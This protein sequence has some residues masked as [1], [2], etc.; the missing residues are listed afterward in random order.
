[1]K[2]TKLL[3]AAFMLLVSQNV[4][5]QM[6][7]LSTNNVKDEKIARLH[8]RIDGNDARFR[9][10]ITGPVN[11]VYNIK[12]YTK[13]NI[14]NPESYHGLLIFHFDI[15][16]FGDRLAYASVTIEGIPTQPTFKTDIS[17]SKN[18]ITIKLTDNNILLDSDFD[19]KTGTAVRPKDPFTTVWGCT[20]GQKTYDLGI[21]LKNNQNLMS[22]V[23]YTCSHSSA[24]MARNGASSRT[25]AITGKKTWGGRIDYYPPVNFN[26]TQTITYSITQ[27]AQNLGIT[28]REAAALIVYEGIQSI[29]LNKQHSAWELSDVEEDIIRYCLYKLYDLDDQTLM[30]VETKIKEN[31]ARSMASS[32]SNLDKL[33][34]IKLSPETNADEL[35]ILAQKTVDQYRKNMSAAV[36]EVQY[37]DAGVGCALAQSFLITSYALKKQYNEVDRLFK[38]GT[39]LLSKKM[40]PLMKF[41]MATCYYLSLTKEYDK[42]AIYG[43]RAFQLLSEVPNIQD[44][45]TRRDAAEKRQELMYTFQNVILGGLIA[46][47]EGKLEARKLALTTYC[48]FCQ[49]PVIETNDN[50]S[51][52]YACELYF[53][54]LIDEMHKALA[55]Q[56]L[57][58]STYKEWTTFDL[59]KFY[60]NYKLALECMN[61]YEKLYKIINNTTSTENSK[62]LKSMKS[63]LQK[64]FLR[65]SSEAAF[66]QIMI[67]KQFNTSNQ[68][69]MIPIYNGIPNT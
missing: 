54:E 16:E 46:A 32:D 22:K 4:L 59:A 42:S 1:M 23:S 56:P 10:F 33:L 15:N 29:P 13:G 52:M 49:S 35:R 6:T 28:P 53:Y 30:T 14:Y 5:C 44:A 63:Y 36:D 50:T 20:T 2:N 47:R 41:Q 8:Y 21:R 12:G 27:I 64:N 24:V 18:A 31:T 51:S 45:F 38:E 3:F 60:I 19:Q 43:S 48:E 17:I 40:Y 55:K 34:A 61:T 26:H 62:G 65:T 9:K 25:N 67:K 69:K 68:N 58:E 57:N 66:D 37:I 39:Q 7:S 11:G